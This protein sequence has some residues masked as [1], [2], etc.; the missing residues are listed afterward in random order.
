MER[1]SAFAGLCNLLLVVLTLKILITL[2]PL[3]AGDKR[4]TLLISKVVADMPKN[5]KLGLVAGLKR[6]AKLRAAVN[7]IDVV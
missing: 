3:A 4:L 1:C 5:T 2:L 7:F 6:L